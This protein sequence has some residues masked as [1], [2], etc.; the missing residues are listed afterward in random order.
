MCVYGVIFESIRRNDNARAIVNKHLK[1]SLC[2]EE[3]KGVYNMKC[4][5]V[6]SE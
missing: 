5:S 2:V 4:G 3:D 6:N 1:P